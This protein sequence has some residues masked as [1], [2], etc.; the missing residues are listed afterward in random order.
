MLVTSGHPFRHR[1]NRQVHIDEALL[2][3]GKGAKE[4]FLHGFFSWKMGVF[5]LQKS[6]PKSF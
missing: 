3:G 1:W 5:S 4:L 6:F 2:G